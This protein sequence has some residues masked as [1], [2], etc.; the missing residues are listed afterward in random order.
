MADQDEIDDWLDSD[1]DDGAGGDA[2]VAPGTPNDSFV[3]DLM[4]PGTTPESL[5]KTDAKTEP[6]PAPAPAPVRMNHANVD[7]KRVVPSAQAVAA[8]R[9]V[10]VSRASNTRTWSL[11]G[12]HEIVYCCRWL[13]AAGPRESV[14][15]PLASSPIACRMSTR[16]F[17]FRAGVPAVHTVPKNCKGK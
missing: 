14:L 13:V 1:S 4:T 3:A 12:L 17:E 7:R 6:A 8:S 16:L 5:R 2:G 10:R 11:R 15:E 9:D